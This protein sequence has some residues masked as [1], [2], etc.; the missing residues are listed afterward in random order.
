MTAATDQTLSEATVHMGSMM[1]DHMAET[2]FM[3]EPPLVRR[4]FEKAL[5]RAIVESWTVLEQDLA[6]KRLGLEGVMRRLGQIDDWAA[7]RLSGHFVL[8]LLRDAEVSHPSWIR[9]MPK[10]LAQRYEELRVAR[11]WSALLN[12]DA[13]SRLRQAIEVERSLGQEGGY[14]Q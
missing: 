3:Q 4:D 8:M 13:M 6:D 2:L 14:E 1:D 7:G 5:Y 9:Y 10:L 12:P 11:I